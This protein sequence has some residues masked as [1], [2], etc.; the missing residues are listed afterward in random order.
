MPR[1]FTKNISIIA[2]CATL[3]RDKRLTE[4]GINGVQA[5]YLPLIAQHPGI[6][7]DQI[8]LDL[9]VNRSSVTRQLAFL[10]DNG[11]ITRQRS[12]SDRRAV[13]VYPTEKCMEVLPHIKDSF[14]EW[15]QELTVNLTEEQLATLEELLDLVAK[16]AEEIE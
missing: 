1:S 5:P 16:R 9:H 14:R 6:T 15:R 13:E 2:R 4:R 3:Y 8:A 10:E 7:Q 11:F 12:A